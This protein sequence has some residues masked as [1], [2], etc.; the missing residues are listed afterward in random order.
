[1]QSNPDGPEGR[2]EADD[3]AEAAWRAIIDNYGDRAE[4]DDPPS[5]DPAA[6]PG[7][8][9]PSAPFGGRFGN[10]TTGADFDEEEDDPF[11][12]EERFE[13]PTPP[14]MPRT[15]PDRLA[16]W[17]G[18]FGSPMVLLAA[19]IFSIEVPTFVAYVLICG[20][21]GGFGY[22]V[23]KMPRGPRDPWDDGAQV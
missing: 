4:L 10:L 3:P 11:L 12:A 5:A 6:P 8:P 13:P 18:I 23:Y 2:G 7:P 17:I 21:V 1:V 19:L 15:T 20:F 22:L 16:A 14:P 9:A